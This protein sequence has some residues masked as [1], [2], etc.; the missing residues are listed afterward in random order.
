MFCGID[1]AIF[2]ADIYAKKL[3]IFYKNREKI[4]TY[5]GLF[6]TIVY[7]AVSISI[8]LIYTIQ[9]IKRS[10]LQV[11]DSTI[12]S[13]EIPYI[14]L[15]NSDL[16]YFAFGVENGAIA[17]RFIDETIYTIRAIYTDNIKNE[18]GTFEVREK[19]DLKVEKCQKEKFGKN[20]QYLFK[21]GEFDNSYCISDFDFILTGG[22]IYDRLSLIKLELFPC[23]NSTEN[24]YH[25]KS[26][27]QID[28]FLAGGY[29]SFLLK[30]IGLNP[31]N[32][33]TPVLPTIKDLYTTISK[34]F[35]R[36]LII[37]YEI[38][39]IKT[40]KGFFWKNMVNERHLRFDRKVESLFL[41]SDDKY[42]KGESIMTVQVRL[43]D[44]IHVQNR[45]Y[46]KMQSVF[47]TTGGYM[48]MINTIFTLLIILP[49]KYYYDNIIVDNLFTFDI[50]KNK[51]HIKHNI[52]HLNRKKCIKDIKKF[53][54]DSQPENFKLKFKKQ[55][56]N[57][58]LNESRSENRSR[59]FLNRN[60]G[61][62]DRSINMSAYE[63]VNNISKLDVID[64]KFLNSNKH[65]FIHKM[66]KYEKSVTETSFNP[67]SGNNMNVNFIGYIFLSKCRDKNKK[68]KLFKKATLL[69]KQKL[70]IINI[71]N[72][73]LFAEKAS[74]E[75][76]FIQYE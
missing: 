36:D 40:D 71:F 39:E 8:F 41:R 42:Y 7:I 16:L 67:A 20:Y 17:T 47:A 38:T 2:D 66:K 13:K 33:S 75:K 24:H 31:Q 43:S 34:Q 62:A 60:V 64:L 76:N 53:K 21:D 61:P 58:I 74:E 57:N 54:R 27:E 45:E 6:L 51:I 28:E 63:K 72:Y 4:S 1:M 11:N 14:N 32:Y 22:F 65:T 69:F 25:C 18:N 73:I 29:F 68:Y 48:Q 55:E 59:N 9:T 3:C 5:F 70:D 52:K 23:K 26:Q 49:N 44:N 56:D 19:K 10:D 37:Y 15:N 30:D 46:K 35:F 50:K 12:Y